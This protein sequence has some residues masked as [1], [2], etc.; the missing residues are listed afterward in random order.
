MKYIS[1]FFAI[2]IPS[3]IFSQDKLYKKV[4]EMPRFP[5]CENMEGTV[6]ELT[7]CSNEKLIQ[8][9]YQNLR[10]PETARKAGVEGTVVIQFVVNKSGKIKNE[11]IARDIG[12]NCGSEALKVVKTMADNSSLN[13][14]PG[15]ENGSPVDVLWT[16]PV[17]FKLEGE[18]D[19]GKDTGNQ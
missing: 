17:K 7:K 1:L 19:E 4:E 2:L 6:K 11:T 8:Y 15:M 12:E 18:N 16:L 5:G 14:R 3:L 13:W 9:I 10:Y